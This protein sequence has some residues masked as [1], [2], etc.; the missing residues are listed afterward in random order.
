MPHL[1]K[2]QE[3]YKAQGLVIIA[4]HHQDVPK[5]KVCGLCQSKHVN[6]TVTNGGRV[7]GDTSNGIPH[8]FLFDTNG[9]CVKE[10][11]PEELTKDL[12]KLM[13]TEPHWITGGRKL[14]AAPVAKVAEGL[15]SGK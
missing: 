11:H 12:E 3:Q 1:V 13:E 2:V 7:Q 14:A 4:A 9:K 6:Y 5:D 8:A 15:K 10:G